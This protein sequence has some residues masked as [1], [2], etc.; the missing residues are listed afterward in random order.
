MIPSIAFV[1]SLSM[2]Y[3]GL[4]LALA[5]LAAADELSG[6]SMMRNPVAD[7]PAGLVDGVNLALGSSCNVGMKVCDGN[8][9]VPILGTCCAVGNGAYCQTGKY[10]VTGGCCPI[11]KICRG[12][13]V[14]CGAGEASCGS[15]CMDAGGNCCNP[16]TGQWCDKGKTCVSGGTK[17]SLGGGSGGGSG[18]SS[19]V[20]GGGQS[21]RTSAIVAPPSSSDIFG[22]GG[23]GGGGVLSSSK[24]SYSLA[25]AATTDGGFG[26]GSGSGSNPTSAS[27]SPSST[28]SSTSGNA[29][30]AV[31]GRHHHDGP[32]RRRRR[33]CRQR[34]EPVA[35]RRVPG[36][37][38]S[39]AVGDSLHEV[40]FGFEKM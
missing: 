16:S 19:I 29:P 24:T 34:A 8:Y 18:L 36:R 30:V 7:G 21:S 3:S 12:D 20:G 38:A 39:I 27:D 14:G 28:S 17:C 25:P 1:T 9:C 32:P 33:W 35:R 2:V 40:V 11:G 37:G 6:Y 10:C 31:R 13:A 4:L 22:G 26:G 23:G 5:G 15:F